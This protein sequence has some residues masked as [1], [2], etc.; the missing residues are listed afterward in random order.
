MIK[1]PIYII[2]YLPDGKLRFKRLG[3][4]QIQLNWLLHL[5][6][7][8]IRV[9]SQNYNYNDYTHNPC[10]TY[11]DI[12]ARNIA[13]ARNQVLKDFY[14]SENLSAFFA[15][16]DAILYEHAMGKEVFHKIEREFAN[17]NPT[18]VDVFSFLN[19]VDQPFNAEYARGEYDYTTQLVFQRKPHF[20]T[21]FFWMRN[22]KQVHGFE[23]YF[24]ESLHEPELIGGEDNEFFIHCYTQNLG[25]YV[26]WNGVIKVMGGMN[27]STWCPSIDNR[28]DSVVKLR[29]YIAKQYG[30]YGVEY[31]NDQLRTRKVQNS[32]PKKVVR[33]NPTETLDTFF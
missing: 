30:E 5:G 2:S 11:Y 28:R 26:C 4:H 27:A 15:D 29:E 14:A 23:P 19:P 33:P 25:T 20:P 10:I 9:F 1:T 31:V 6:F 24:D 22:L 7:T 21:Q 13:Y 17:D 12:P 8:D 32:K 16:D 3:N 18:D